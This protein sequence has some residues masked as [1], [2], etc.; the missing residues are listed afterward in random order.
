MKLKLK[1]GC[2]YIPQHSRALSQPQEKPILLQP[3]ASPQSPSPLTLPSILCPDGGGKLQ[4][5]L[6]FLSA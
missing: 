6:G 1:T 5:D 4:A 2:S 3:F